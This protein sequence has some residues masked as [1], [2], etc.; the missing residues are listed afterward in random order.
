MILD[1]CLDLPK[2]SYPPWPTQTNFDKQSNVGPIEG[3]LTHINTVE[4]G[5]K[6]KK[7]FWVNT[8]S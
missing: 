1:P 7:L 2:D 8:K 6:N 3:Q 5:M 4:D